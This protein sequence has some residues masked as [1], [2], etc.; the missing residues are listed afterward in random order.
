MTEFIIRSREREC[1]YYICNYAFSNPITVLLCLFPSPH[2]MNSESMAAFSSS[3]SLPRPPWVGR[4]RLTLPH[5]TGPLVE[6]SI[7]LLSL[8]T[9]V[10][11]L[12][13]WWRPY[14]SSPLPGPSSHVPHPHQS[15]AK[16][17]RA[18]RRNVVACPH[19]A[20][21]YFQRLFPPK[22]RVR[23]SGE[24]LRPEPLAEIV[25]LPNWFSIAITFSRDFLLIH[26]MGEG[27]D[28][29]KIIYRR[30]AWTVIE[31]AKGFLAACRS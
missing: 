12:T 7:P 11:P 23:P 20:R 22:K 18:T 17:K 5:P 24:E 16:V 2:H 28:P 4:D 1:I 8:V 6:S 14:Q 26:H 29:A 27:L 13:R 31:A 15:A 25:E 10:E 9:S 30:P 21:S 3:S 19:R